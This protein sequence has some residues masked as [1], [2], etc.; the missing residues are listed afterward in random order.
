MSNKCGCLKLN[1]IALGF[2]MGIASGVFMMALA[3]SAWVWGVGAVLLQQYVALFPGYEASLNGGLY[4]LG[5]GILVGFAFGLVLGIV[6]D[7][8][9]CCR[10]CPCCCCKSTDKN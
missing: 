6:Y 10:S 4:G 8:C 9:L 1:P 2:A 5:W 7:I 3:W